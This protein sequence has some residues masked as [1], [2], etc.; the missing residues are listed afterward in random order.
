MD[1]VTKIFKFTEKKQRFPV[2]ARVPQTLWYSFWTP[3]LPLDGICPEQHIRCLQ[4]FHL[5]LWTVCGSM[6]EKLP[7][8]TSNQLFV[9]K[10]SPIIWISCSSS[11]LGF[12]YFSDVGILSG[13]FRYPKASRTQGSDFWSA[14]TTWAVHRYWPYNYCPQKPACG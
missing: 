1:A 6:L 9:K 13:W 7:K 8:L 10:I 2:V 3:G 12:R 4:N 11:G 5:K 14:E